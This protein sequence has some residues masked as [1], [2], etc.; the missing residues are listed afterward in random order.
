MTHYYDK[1]HDGPL[2]PFHVS[3][4][5]RGKEM[6]LW[7][8]S[9]VFSKDELDAGSRLLIESCVMEDGWKV[10]DLGCGI[11]VV[12]I[13]IKACFPACTVL[14][15]D[16]SERAVDLTKKNVEEMNMEIEVRQ[17][18]GYEEVPEMFDTVLVNPP[19]VAGRETVFRLLSEAA[20]HVRPGGLVQAVA[21]HQKGGAMIGK[22]LKEL[23]G[24]CDD[25]RKKGGFRIYV[26]RKEE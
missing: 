19:Y 4:R 22:H 10:H 12:G 3:I 14:C 8:A 26:A 5:A 20:E 15:T 13:V 7:S 23:L 9:G 16:V 1:V 18:N 24:N 2:Q 21:R 25:S 6:T 11:G 17:S